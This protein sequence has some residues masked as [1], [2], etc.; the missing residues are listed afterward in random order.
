[1][2]ASHPSRTAVRQMRSCPRL[3]DVGFIMIGVPHDAL[4]GVCGL[5]WQV[6]C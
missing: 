6:L 1:M 2:A 3:V 4:T 5:A